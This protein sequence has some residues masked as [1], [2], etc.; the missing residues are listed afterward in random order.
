MANPFIKTNRW[1]ISLLLTILL[2]SIN[3]NGQEDTLVVVDDYDKSRILVSKKDFIKEISSTLKD[4]TKYELIQYVNTVQDS[5]VLF[6][7]FF[8][9]ATVTQPKDL[10]VILFNLFNQNKIRFQVGT[11]TIKPDQ[12]K[13]KTIRVY[14]FN[15]IYIGKDWGLFYNEKLITSFEKTRNRRAYRAYT[16]F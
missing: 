9:N 7:Q 12:I 11:E 14:R 15:S 2:T 1:K 10:D 13:V 16:P 6:D 8:L 3:S 4:S 5:L